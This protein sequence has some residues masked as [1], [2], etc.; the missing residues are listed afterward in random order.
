MKSF[1]ISLGANRFTKEP[2]SM[3]APIPIW[4]C[5]PLPAR[6]IIGLA[7]KLTSRPAMRNTS[8]IMVRTN[9]SL[10]AA[11]RA[12]ANLQSTSI[13][14]HTEIIRPFSSR[15]ALIPPTSLWPISTFRPYLSISIT[16]RS[17]AV[18]TIPWVRCQYCSCITW[19]ACISST[20]ASDR[21]V[22]TQNSSSVAEV[23][24]MSLILVASIFSR[25]E[26]FALLWNRSS[27]CFFTKVK[28]SARTARESTRLPSWIRKAGIRRVPIGRSVSSS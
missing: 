23:K 19:E 28:V 27:N 18:R 1:F 8:R 16:A 24:L 14:S 22:F 2:S 20:I 5:S 26:I 25:P 12:S 11:C 9:S 21:G 6:P 15:W 13:C 3:I 17:N 7:L 10:S 4:V